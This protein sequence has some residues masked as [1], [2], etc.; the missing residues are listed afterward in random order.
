MNG[1]VARRRGRFYAVIYEGLDPVT[2]RERRT[3]HPAGTDRAAAERLVARLAIEEQGRADQVRGLS[4]GAYLTGQWLPGK[5]LQLATSTYR[6]YERNVHRHVLPALGRIGLRRLRH[7]H[8]EA[9]YDQ[10]L[11]P[12]IERPPLA[13]KTIYEV[14]L[15]IRGALDEA[16]R[17]GLL[18]RNVAL[19]ARSPRLK[20]IQKTE[21]QSWTAEQLQQFLRAAAGHRLFPLLWLAAITGMRRNEVLGL[22][23][24]D[25]DFQKKTI[26][27]NRG[28]VAVGYELHETRGKTRNARRPIDLGATTLALLAG[29]RAHQT[30]E[31]AAVGVDDAGWVFAD[32]DGE[33]IHPHALSQAFERITRRAGVPVIRLHDLRHTH[34]TLLIKEGVPVKVVSE[35]LGHANIAFTIETYQHVLPGMR[36]DAATLFE[37]VVTGDALLP[38][39][40]NP[41]EGRK[42]P[43]KNTA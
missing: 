20:A 27:L 8:I 2:G 35:R 34:G 40:D 16:V 36:A 32:G 10:L 17:R 29:W 42:K 11:T 12:S 13:P 22:K 15:V 24:D 38:A 9:L 31:F 33:P 23:W 3:W 18:T 7:H 28:L 1:Y 39:V 30:A 25:I 19:I 6:G 21:A 43:R 41:V 26:S 14:H 5:K 4:F 37:Q